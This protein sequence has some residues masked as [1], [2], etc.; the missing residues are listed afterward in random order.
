MAHP[1]PLLFMSLASAAAFTT[2]TL[3]PSS[4]TRLAT[5]VQMGLIRRASKIFRRTNTRDVDVSFAEAAVNELLDRES[6]TSP[7]AD[8]IDEVVDAAQTASSVAPT[9][10]DI[11]SPSTWQEALLGGPKAIHAAAM[12]AMAEADEKAAA[13][14]VAYPPL[15]AS[16]TLDSLFAPIFASRELKSLYAQLDEAIDRDEWDAADALKAK[17][18]LAKARRAL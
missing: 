5:P 13:E 3:S 8:V 6:S 7:M 11:E 14:R 10:N 4:V 15:T 18:D 17:I 12:A 16:A 9:G 2:L 1:V